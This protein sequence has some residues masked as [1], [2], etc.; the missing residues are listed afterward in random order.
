MVSFQLCRPVES[1]WAQEIE[2]NHLFLF[3]GLTADQF[4]RPLKQSAPT[5]KG[6][7]HQTRVNQYLKNTKEPVNSPFLPLEKYISKYKTV[8]DNKINSIYCSIIATMH[9]Q[10]F[11]KLTSRLPV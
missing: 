2:D 1:T 9:R 4:K 10:T 8:Q 6:H 5:I 11:S 7:M 3:L